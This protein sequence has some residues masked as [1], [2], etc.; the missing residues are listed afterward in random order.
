LQPLYRQFPGQPLVSISNSQREPLWFADWV[1]TVYHGLPTNLY[2]A[3]DQP[4]D[5]LAFLGRISKEKQPDHAIE[6]ALQTGIPL[7]IAAKVDRNDREYYTSVIEPLLRKAGSGVEFIGEIGGEDKV[8]FLANARALLFPIGWPEPF[9]LVMIEALA[10]GTPVIAY[11]CGS[12]PELIEEGVTG[13][14]VQDIPEA[15]KAV[16]RIP[17]LNRAKC[18]S[19]FEQRFSAA[20]MAQSYA[21]IYQRVL[22]RSDRPSASKPAHS[23]IEKPHSAP[24]NRSPSFRMS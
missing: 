23:T 10:C 2:T 17:E 11:R 7:K 12:V 15:V 6:I 21:E 4:G 24:K 8:K 1:G 14:M 18:R 22:E 5:Y 19:Q 9:G 3:Q 16:A 20:R 13:F